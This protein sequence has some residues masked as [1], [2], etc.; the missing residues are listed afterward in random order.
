MWVSNFDL[1]V[2]VFHVKRPVNIPLSWYR[3]NRVLTSYMFWRSW[4]AGIRL[5]VKSSLRVMNCVVLYTVYQNLIWPPIWDDT[6]PL[7]PLKIH[8]FL[9]PPGLSVFDVCCRVF[10]SLKF[11]RLHLYSYCFTVK[12]YFS[13]ANTQSTICAPV[14]VRPLFHYSMQRALTLSVWH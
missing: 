13:L 8:N 10:L 14:I 3:E 9:L 5:P 11:F 2:L 4:V 7:L 6:S 12:S 1:I